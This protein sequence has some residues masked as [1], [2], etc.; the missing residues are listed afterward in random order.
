M[1][2][3]T[4][5]IHSD[6]Q[7][8]GKA[9]DQQQLSKVACNFIKEGSEYDQQI[10]EF[11]LDW[12]SDNSATIQLQTSGSTGT[13]KTIEV[14]KQKMYHSAVATGNRLKL[15]ANTKALCCLPINF[16]AGKM[17]LVRA[18]VLGWHID[19]IKPSSNPLATIE[20]NYDFTALTPHQL[21]NSLENI[22]KF[23]KVIIGGAPMSMELKN[24]VKNVS[25]KIYE[26]YGMT[27]TLSHVA[28]RRINPKKN[29]QEKA[30]KAVKY[31]TFK[32]D[33]NGCLII[34]APKILDAPITTTDIVDLVDEKRFFWKGRLDFVINSGGIK[35]FPEEIEKKL[36]SL[37][38]VPFFV[39]GIPDER[40][41]QKVALFVE[42]DSLEKVNQLQ[43]LIAESSLLSRYQLPK[44]IIHLP[45]FVYT[46]T[47]KLNRLASLEQLK[48]S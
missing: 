30:F 10:G 3:I 16:I 42:T 33:K 47:G 40:L 46:P 8:N 43:E 32:Q 28:L 31:V 23:K 35:I 13:P 26:T 14:E 1:N 18:M 7:L 36:H 6:F 38:D 15:S 2:T 21:A 25:T 12:L 29:T 27:E 19:I 34:E 48:V 5:P 4:L 20:K 22:G 45:T 41:G 24:E 17:M 11:I 9:L 37:I 39:S 44:E